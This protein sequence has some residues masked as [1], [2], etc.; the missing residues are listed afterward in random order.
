MKKKPFTKL[1][2]SLY[3]KRVRVYRNLH[4][5]CFSVKCL[6]ENCVIAHLDKIVLRD[7][8]FPVSQAGRERVL[9]EKNKNVHAFIEGYICKENEFTEE[10]RS[11]TYNPYKKNYFF[12]K[13][14]GREIKNAT[15]VSVSLQ[16]VFAH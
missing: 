15:K 13:S 12:Y 1:N 8:R 9:R 16:G 5:D 7:A 4:K 3:G 10:G 14:N 2:R 11:I 6:D